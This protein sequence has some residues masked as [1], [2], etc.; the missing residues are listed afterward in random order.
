MGLI[1][2]ACLTVGG[3]LNAKAAFNLF[4]VWSMNQ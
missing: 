2:V 3:R 4:W 1:R